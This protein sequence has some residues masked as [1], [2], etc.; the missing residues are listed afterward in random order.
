M[1]K[2]LKLFATDMDGTLLRDDH[3]FNHARL[4]AILREFNKKNLTFA[5]SS[6]RSLLALQELFDGFADDMAFVA[7]NGG[8]VAVKDEIIFAQDFTLPQISEIIQ[9]LREMPYS[10]AD[11]FLISGLKGAYALQGI[12]SEFFKAAQFYYPNSQKVNEIG[13]IDDALLKI[14]TNFPVEHT[15]ECEAFISEHLPYARATTTGFTSIDIIPQGISKATG[16]EK[17]LDALHLTNANLAAFGDQMNDLEMLKYAS[18]A[19]TSYAVSNAYPDILKVADEIIGS[20]NED[21]VFAKIER[22]IGGK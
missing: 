13:A 16:L 1:K 5:A 8:V 11:D 22:I 9:L 6:G 14:T 7:E 12:S 10:P 15:L 21:G 19:G 17:L 20:N 18:Q 3:T 4:H 2:E